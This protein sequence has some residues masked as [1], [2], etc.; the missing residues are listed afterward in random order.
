M[1]KNLFWFSLSSL[2]LILMKSGKDY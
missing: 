2:E 1:L